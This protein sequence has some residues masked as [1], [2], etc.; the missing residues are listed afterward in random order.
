M[1]SYNPVFW[2][3]ETLALRLRV[4]PMEPHCLG[5]IPSDQYTDH[6]LVGLKGLVFSTSDV[7][8]S[9]AVVRIM[10]VNT[11]KCVNS[12]LSPHEG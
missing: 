9:R 3:R 4:S 2:R 1:D 11:S 6:G 8:K 7:N 10:G 5:L 12:L